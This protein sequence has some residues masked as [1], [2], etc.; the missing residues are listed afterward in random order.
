MLVLTNQPFF[1]PAIAND[2]IAYSLN[3]VFAI[4]KYSDYFSIHTKSSKYLTVL[5]TELLKLKVLE[6]L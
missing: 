4:Q 3:L 1:G 5:Q 6:S 2:F